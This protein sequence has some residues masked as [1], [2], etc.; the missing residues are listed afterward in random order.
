MEPLG[1]KCYDT[2]SKQLFEC[3]STS[4]LGRKNHL[5]FCLI[6]GQWVTLYFVFEYKAYR[7]AY[8]E[9]LDY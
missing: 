7:N 5:Y 6:G 8:E 9:T 2:S 4:R 3:Y 1:K